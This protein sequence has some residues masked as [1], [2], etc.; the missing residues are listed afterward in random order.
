VKGNPSLLYSIFR[1]LMDNAINYA[2]QGTAIEVSA[3]KQKD[4]WHFTFKDNGIGIPDKHLPRIFERFYRID[5]GRSRDMGGTGL[6]LSIVKNAVVLHGGTITVS[7]IAPQ[8]LR[9][10]FTLSK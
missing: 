4:C 5:K 9:F 8:G 6:G 2:G 3:E 1:N 10:D 7:N